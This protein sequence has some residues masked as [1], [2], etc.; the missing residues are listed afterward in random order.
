MDHPPSLPPVEEFTA[1]EREALGP[2]VTNTDLPVFALQNLSEVTKGALFARYSRS[3]K[4]LRR[5]LLDEFL[6][7]GPPARG[8]A[9]GQDQAEDFFE[10]VFIGFG[11]D[12]VAQLGAVHLACEGASNILT[13]VLEWGRFAA[14]LEQSTRY[15][16]YTD[17]P[18]GRYRYHVPRELCAAPDLQRRYTQALDL[19]F[20]TYCRWLEPL[21]EHLRAQHPRPADMTPA[22]HRSAIKAKALDNLRGLLPAATRSNVGIFGSGQAMEN[23]LLRMRA[24]PQSEVRAYAALMLQELR[25]V[26]PA[27]VKRV[28]LPDRGGRWSAYLEEVGQ[29]TAA[30]AQALL[31]P[32]PEAAPTEPYVALTEHDPEG[33][34]KTVAAALY[35]VSTLSDAELLERARRMSAGER[36]RVLRAYVGQRDNRRH[37]P[38]RA[39]ERTA[40]RFDVVADYGAFRDLQR[41]RPLTLEWQPLS[42]RHG[43]AVP[44][45]L[46]QVGGAADYRA[47]MQASAAA[48]DALLGAGLAAAAPYAVCLGFRVRFYMQLNARAAMHMLELRTSPQ[49]HEAYRRICQQM[50]RLIRDEAGHAGIAAAMR[51][52]NHEPVALGAR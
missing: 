45:V 49:G 19:A 20:D 17:R 31:G 11:D 15:I 29:Q 22:A 51:F 32:P 50:H 3:P 30:A 26:I 23:L 12:S 7:A 16:P 14:Y 13:K 38:G 36:A 46:Q 27:L 44:P 35:A 2:Y 10:R 1:A 41:H 8:P 52:V 43:Y 48:H 37:R 21:K 34:V 5:L 42:P 28:D 33:E 47:V 25:K 39:F 40:Y 9:A 24:A 6:P 4:S 18:G